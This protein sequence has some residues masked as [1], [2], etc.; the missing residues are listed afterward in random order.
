[1]KIDKILKLARIEIEEEEK[2]QIEKEFLAILDF[3][4]EIEKIDISNVKPMN[5]PQ[6][7]YNVMREDKENQKENQKMK[8]KKL[9]NAAP[10]TKDNYIKVKQVL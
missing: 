5:Y 2:K 9:L 7:I 4:K 6:E 1:M 10:D 8:R 3:I